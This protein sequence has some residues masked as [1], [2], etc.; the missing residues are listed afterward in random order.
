MIYIIHKYEQYILKL[1]M[2]LSVYIISLATFLILI[3]YTPAYACNVC[4][5]KDPKMVDMHR[6]LGFKDCFVC[7]GPG[8]KRL[9]LDQKKQMNTDP[10]CFG[11]HRK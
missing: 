1:I 7:H 11:C 4:H 5:S 10:L 8:S 9:A 6:A 2:R 3:A